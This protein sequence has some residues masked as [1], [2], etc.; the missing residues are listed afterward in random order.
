[1]P[2]P[3]P[4]P[5][6]RSGHMREQ[7]ALADRTTLKIGG[8]A[9]W[10]VS[11]RDIEELSS[12]WRTLHPETP[13]F[14]LG[15][16]SNLL[17]GDSGFQGVILDM[18]RGF[19]RIQLERPSRTD[20]PEAVVT[21]L[22]GTSTRALAHAARR[23]GLG[24][25][26]FLAGIPGSVGGALVMN[27]GAHGHELKDILID[28]LLLDPDGERH[29]MTPADLD[30]SYRHTAL[31]QGWIFVS[32]RFRLR[33]EDPDTIRQTMRHHNHQRRRAQPL[34]LP[35][36]GSTF[37]NPPD[38][39]AAWK[40]IDAAGMRGVAI[41]DARVA[42]KHCNFLVNTGKATA[43]DMVALIQ[44]VRNAV[45]AHSGIRLDTEIGFLG[46]TGPEPL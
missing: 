43:T 42:E 40:L 10:L 26:E 37:K 21:A 30:M 8:P 45:F 3:V 23:L 36:A 29:L 9:R 19:A 38:G 27:A 28:A 16:G 2:S 12:F 1:M 13:R 46:P 20:A 35:S 34:N 14:I 24:G 44:K 11:F 15:G 33:P 7:V 6:G 39:P 22:S 4:P 17:V 31:P 18:T 5:P 41:G 32:A 25:A